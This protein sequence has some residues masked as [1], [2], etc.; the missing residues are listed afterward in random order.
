M[1]TDANNVRQLR[2]SGSRRRAKIPAARTRWTTHVPGK[3]RRTAKPFDGARFR[4]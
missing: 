1:A 2:N 4:L 3:P